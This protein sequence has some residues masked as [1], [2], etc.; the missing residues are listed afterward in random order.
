M[1]IS[2]GIYSSDILGSTPFLAISHGWVLPTMGLRTEAGVGLGFAQSGYSRKVYNAVLLEHDYLITGEA[3]I[4][5]P[6]RGFLDARAPGLAIPRFV[7]GMVVMNQGG[8]PNLGA[9]LGFSHRTPV[10]FMARSNAW[11]LQ[12]SVR[13]HI[14]VQRL[15]YER[16]GMA[17]N[18]SILV[19]IQRFY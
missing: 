6:M 7:F 2:T 15:A 18:L 3:L 1:A 9:A 5:L 14:V 4:V 16:T 11:V 8:M 17:H 13:D 12:W 10:P 19:G